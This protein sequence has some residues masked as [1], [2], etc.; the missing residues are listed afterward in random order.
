MKPCHVGYKKPQW[1]AAW[2]DAAKTKQRPEPWQEKT[3]DG[4]AAVC[5]EPAAAR[6]HNP[7]DTAAIRGEGSRRASTSNIGPAS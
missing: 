4:S 5:G 6:P 2:I 1:N 3:C 7:L